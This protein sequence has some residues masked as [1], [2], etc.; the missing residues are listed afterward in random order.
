MGEEAD[1]LIEQGMDEVE[2]DEFDEY[3]IYEFAPEYA[4]PIWSTERN[5]TSSELCL[6]A[7]LSLHAAHMTPDN[8]S[9]P[10]IGTDTDISD[11]IRKFFD[12]LNLT[13]NWPTRL[14]IHSQLYFAEVSDYTDRLLM[15]ENAAVNSDRVMFFTQPGLEFC[16]KMLRE[17]LTDSNKRDIIIWL[18]YKVDFDIRTFIEGDPMKTRVRTEQNFPSYLKL[19]SQIEKVQEQMDL[20]ETKRH[21][22]I[23][24][25]QAAKWRSDRKIWRDSYGVEVKYS[26][27]TEVHLKN[28]IGFLTS[29]SEDPKYSHIALKGLQEELNLRNK[30]KK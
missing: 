3:D 16:K 18:S 22:I 15:T 2:F 10:S 26:E 27:M 1:R 12:I 8:N 29:N 9:Y 17:L 19:N 25:H 20:L 24:S 21:E 6:L 13:I 4:T 23:W 28:A 14:D 30:K 7:S 5:L 11:R